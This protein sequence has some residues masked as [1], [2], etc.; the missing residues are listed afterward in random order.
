MGLARGFGASQRV[1]CG[2]LGG[3]DGDGLSDDV[4]ASRG[5]AMAVGAI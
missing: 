2:P 4:E 3:D 5:K 1:I